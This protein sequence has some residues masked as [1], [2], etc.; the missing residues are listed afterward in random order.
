MPLY[1]RKGKK[2]EI[3]FNEKRIYIPRSRA[4][5][6]FDSNPAAET[7]LSPQRALLLQQD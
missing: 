2:K 4:F 5:V 3:Y 1:Y 6:I 7:V